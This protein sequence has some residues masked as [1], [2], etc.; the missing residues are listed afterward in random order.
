MN[1]NQFE[2]AL[3]RYGA[4][5][6]RWPAADRVA[7]EAL[8][9]SDPSAARLLDEALRLDRLLARSVE[10]LPVDAAILGGIIAGIGDGRYR[11]QTLRPTRR[12]AVWAGAAM[13]ASL[14]VGFIAG[15]ALPANQGEDTLAGLMFGTNTTTTTDSGSVL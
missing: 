12:L 15:V 1:M 9:A 13:A 14:V 11:D 5:P 2:E 8:I 6:G 3:S 10:P 7:C 4:D